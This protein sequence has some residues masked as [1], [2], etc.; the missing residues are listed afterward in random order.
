MA[1]AEFHEVVAADFDKFYAAVTAYEQ[2]PQF[3]EGC[4]KADVERK[5]P[6]AAVVTYHV[7][8]VKDVV[9]T[10]E[11]KEDREKGRVDWKLITSD[12]F[13]SNQGFWQLKSAG[14]GKTDVHYRLEVEFKIPVPGFI[15]NRIIKGQ[16]PSMMKNFQEKAKRG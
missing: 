7:S 14:P 12:F 9:Y 1:V 8:M 2:Y 16:L 13:K 6:S 10:L 11:H 15:L 3:V 5:G 4:T